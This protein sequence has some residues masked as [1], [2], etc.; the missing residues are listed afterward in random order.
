MAIDLVERRLLP[1]ER[2]FAMIGKTDGKVSLPVRR[3]RHLVVTAKINAAKDDMTTSLVTK[4]GAV[5]RQ[6]N[7][8]WPGGIE[9][10]VRFRRTSSAMPRDT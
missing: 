10:V 7:S 4:A 2:A 6:A 3:K 8:T 1:Y 5:A 9:T